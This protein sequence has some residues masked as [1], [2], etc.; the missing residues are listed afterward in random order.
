MITREQVGKTNWVARELSIG[1]DLVALTNGS[2]VV[3]YKFLGITFYTR[4]DSWE[5]TGNTTLVDMADTRKSQ[6][7][8][9]T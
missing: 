6:V 7:G 9:K 8:F 2:T 4:K 5:N 1:G 3:K